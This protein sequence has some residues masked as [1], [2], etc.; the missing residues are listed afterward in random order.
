MQE[1]ADC[2]TGEF[3]SCSAQRFRSTAKCL[4]CKVGRREYRVL[5]RPALK[6][7]D[8]QTGSNGD[9]ICESTFMSNGCRFPKEHLL[10]G[11]FSDFACGSFWQEKRVAEGAY[12][13]LMERY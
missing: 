6:H 9:C 10:F 4:L 8:L 12:G 11:R 2:E 5:S 3:D 1:A 13:E 7:C